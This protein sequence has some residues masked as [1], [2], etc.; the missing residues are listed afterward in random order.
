MA[1]ATFVENSEA[2]ERSLAVIS[3]NNPEQ[4]RDLLGKMFDEQSVTVTDRELDAHTENTSTDMVYLLDGEEVIAT[5]PLA[6]VA[7]SILLVNSDLY[8]TGARDVRDVDPPAVIAALDETYFRLRG[9]PESNKQKLLLIT[10]SRYIERL[11][12]E[13]QTGTHRAS[14]QHLSRIKDERGTETV[15]EK[16]AATPVDVHVYGTP[17]W[18]PSPDSGFTMHGGWNPDFRDSWFVIH[19]PDDASQPHAALLAV[20]DGPRAWESFW[21]YDSETVRDLNRYVEREM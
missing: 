5:S 18:T 15:Y 12:L 9:Y 21:T 4:F 16:L 17:D 13:H 11:S 1:L 10:I 20:K 14:F 7:D 19:V 6:E 2:P 8:T 3:R